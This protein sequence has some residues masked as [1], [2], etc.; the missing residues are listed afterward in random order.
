MDVE[1]GTSSNVV[2]GAIPRRSGFNEEG[3]LSSNALPAY[4]PLLKSS[5]GLTPVLEDLAELQLSSAK[6]Q[7]RDDSDL[8][9]TTPSQ[10]FLAADNHLTPGNAQLRVP[11]SNSAPG[12][13]GE[14]P[15]L[16][17]GGPQ[18]GMQNE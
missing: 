16:A 17:E 11:T 6:R 5:I 2:G 3:L 13:T 1:H 9:P 8:I 12:G 15:A 7:S 10:F 18:L 14:M 4:A